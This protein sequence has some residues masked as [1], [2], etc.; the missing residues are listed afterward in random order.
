MNYPSPTQE[1]QYRYTLL[2][3]KDPEKG[4]NSENLDQMFT[5]S[6][7]KEFYNEVLEHEEVRMHNLGRFVVMVDRIKTST[8]SLGI[9]VGE[10]SE[11]IQDEGRSQEAAIEG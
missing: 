11:S 8:H 3:K 9:A 6:D 7:K 1:T 2:R 5:K 10:I 4:D